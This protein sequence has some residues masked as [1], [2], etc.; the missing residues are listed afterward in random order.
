MAHG[1]R[2]DGGQLALCDQGSVRSS[3]RP[4][5]V[6]GSYPP[7]GGPAAAA[8]V[9][10]VRRAWADGREVVVVSPRPGAAPLVMPVAGAAVGRAISRLR[11]GPGSSAR[12]WAAITL[13]LEPGW[14]FGRGRRP[15]PGPPLRPADLKRTARA[16]AAALSRFDQAELAVTGH[17]G[18]P[19]D[20]LAPL[21][22]AVQ[23][24]TAS[25][26]DVAAWLRAAGAPGVSVVEPY[27][28]AG[29]RPPGSVRAGSARAGSGGRRRAGRGGQ[30]A[31]AGRVAA[32]NKRSAPVGPRRPEGA[33]PTNAGGARATS[34]RRGPA[35]DEACPG[36]DSRPGR[37]KVALSPLL[38]T[39]VSSIF[40]RRT[41]A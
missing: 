20:V 36:C 12:R 26:E 15:D 13:C 25:S 27:A 11:P 32:G 22:P 7:A 34:S 33:R 31:R 39:G 6:V 38:Q 37:I 41:V 8:T 5:L 28:G 3:P 29:L 2:P 19:R 30:P 1:P 9:A 14:P 23:R 40:R 17:L 16:L 21:W 24:V 18:V 4:C 35:P 10:A